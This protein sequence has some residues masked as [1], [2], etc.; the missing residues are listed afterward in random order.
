MQWELPTAL[1]EYVS[2][3]AKKSSTMLFINASPFVQ[4]TNLITHDVDFLF[5]NF[6]ELEKISMMKID[7]EIDL[8]K[9]FAI[10]KYRKITKHFIVFGLT[11]IYHYHRGKINKFKK[12]VVNHR[13]NVGVSDCFIGAFAVAIMEQ[14]ALS[15][16][17][18]FAMASSALAALKNSVSEELP[19]R[20]DVELFIHDVSQ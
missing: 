4:E 16:S 14:R 19:S 9:A 6:V 11:H 1:V 7:N 8:E 12:Y 17:I 20:S 5:C 2:K 10:L 18:E 3:K 13:N 15:E